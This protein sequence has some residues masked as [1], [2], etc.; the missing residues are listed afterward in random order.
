MSKTT[1]ANFD[2]E[3][4]IFPY[5]RNAVNKMAYILIEMFT[6]SNDNTTRHFCFVFCITLFCCC[7]VIFCYRSTVSSMV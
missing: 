4:I 2:D 1:F 7:F 3:V 5:Y 6:K